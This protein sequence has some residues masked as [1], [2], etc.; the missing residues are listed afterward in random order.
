M[1]RRARILFRSTRPTPRQLPWAHPG[2]S[3]RG[4]SRTGRR[5]P[6][7]IDPVVIAAR[8]MVEGK[9]RS[10]RPSV[11]QEPD[12]DRE[13]QG[14]GGDPRSSVAIAG[15]DGPEDD[16]RH[17]ERPAGFGAGPADLSYDL[18]E[19]RPGRP[20]V[21]HDGR[22]IEAPRRHH[23]A[24][25]TTLS[26][27]PISTIASKRC[28]GLSPPAEPGQQLDP[29]RPVV[30]RAGHLLVRRAVEPAL[31]APCRSRR[32]RCPPP[33]SRRTDWG[34]GTGRPRRAC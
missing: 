21:D 2:E 27:E 14:N 12:G 7:T 10:V 3:W 22:Q 25:G 17:E 26:P 30:E 1:I 34:A 9:L 11:Y 16:D 18:L 32:R 33:R 23:H 29:R 13:D 6:A 4:S 31:H 19:P 24:L 5:A 20:A 15:I 28:A 8:A